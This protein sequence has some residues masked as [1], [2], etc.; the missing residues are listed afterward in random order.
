MGSSSETFA[1]VEIYDLGEILSSKNTSSTLLY[2]EEYK[3]LKNHFKPDADF[4]IPKK[5][6][7][8]CNRL[9]KADYLTHEFVYSSS[10]DYVFCVC[11]T[12]F[13]DIQGKL[14]SSFMDTHGYSKL[15]LNKFIPSKGNRTMDGID[16][17]V[18]S[19]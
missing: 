16:S 6:L 15:P 5:L 1:P 10:K 9:C 12:L 13:P 18:Q 4:N 11:C 14:K 3:V 2:H 19:V 7:H 8:N 17:T